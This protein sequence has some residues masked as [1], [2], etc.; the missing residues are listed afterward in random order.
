[1]DRVGER[2]AVRV[3]KILGELGRVEGLDISLLGATAEFGIPQ[4]EV[5]TGLGVRGGG[6]NKLP[7]LAVKVVE[8]RVWFALKGGGTG[9]VKRGATKV[10]EARGEGL[11]G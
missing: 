9:V 3:G 10:E 8:K 1:V 5:G 11:T 2:G 7:L 6:G 4:P